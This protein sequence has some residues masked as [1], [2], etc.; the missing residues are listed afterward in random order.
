MKK[1]TIEEKIEQAGEKYKQKLREKIGALL[2][3]KGPNA[4]TLD[5]IESLWGPRK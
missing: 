3:I 2:T 1:V 5:G 4:I